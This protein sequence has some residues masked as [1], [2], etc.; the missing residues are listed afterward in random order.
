M[1]GLLL[2]TVTI[3]VATTGILPN[4][5]NPIQSVSAS[6]S[7]KSCD[8]FDKSPNGQANYNPHCLDELGIGPS[9][10]NCKKHTDLSACRLNPDVP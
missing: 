3:V 9:I 6:P 8:N 10:P 4:I 5:S 2:A 7:S 1:Y